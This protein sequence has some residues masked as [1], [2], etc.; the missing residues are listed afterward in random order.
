MVTLKQFRAYVTG[1]LIS[2]VIIMLLSFYLTENFKLWYIYSYA[3][4][5]VIGDIFKYFFDTDITFKRKKED[6]ALK[7]FLVIF[8]GIIL[9][10]ASVALMTS[11]LKLN[12]LL[13]IV[14][15]GMLFSILSF[16]INKRWVF[17]A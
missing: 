16:N 4:A 12:Y 14:I 10:L 11:V 15:T 8:V 17:Y 6:S 7:F 1:G 3:I 2:F 13:S 9:S 5:L